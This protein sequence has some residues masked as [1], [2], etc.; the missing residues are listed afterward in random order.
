MI[1]VPSTAPSSY[2]VSETALA[3]PAFAGGALARISSFDT[4]SAAPI[5]TPSETKA[6]DQQRQR[7][8]ARAD[9]DQ[10]VAEDREAQRRRARRRAGRRASRSAPRR[11]RRRSSSSSPGT[12][13]SPASIGDRPDDQL[14]VLSDEVQEADESDHAE[15]VHE[16]RAGEASGGGT[17][18]CR[19]WASRAGSGGARTARR[20]RCPR[21]RGRAAAGSRRRAPRTP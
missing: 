11:C 20:T 21:R 7:T 13:A 9:G 8:G 10:Q 4:V 12:R 15:Q 6:D 17:A 16:H 5:P 1:V 18:P 2:A 3:A 19:A 14:Q